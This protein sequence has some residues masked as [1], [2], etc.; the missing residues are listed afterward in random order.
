MYRKQYH[1]QTNDDAREL[2]GFQS[3]E[4][5][6]R[7]DFWELMREDEKVAAEAF[8]LAVEEAAA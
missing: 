6:S 8:F 7:S 2:Y 1:R 5:M 4:E 3:Y